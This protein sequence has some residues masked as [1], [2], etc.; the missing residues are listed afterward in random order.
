MKSNEPKCN[1]CNQGT[2]KRKKKFR[3]SGPAV[4]IGYIFLIPSILGILFGLTLLFGTGAATTE[5][6]KTMKEG[7]RTHL[8]EANLPQAIIEEVANGRKI[9]QSQKDSLSQ[10]QRIAIESAEMTYSASMVGTGAGAAI[11]G[12]FSIF[13]IFSSFIGGLVG[14]LLTMKKWVLQCTGCG[15]V[16]NAS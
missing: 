11:A 16:V 2:L 6:S 7:I 10:N 8:L 3:L 14:W 13:V 1:V 5:S 4:F 15:A 12:G 9:S